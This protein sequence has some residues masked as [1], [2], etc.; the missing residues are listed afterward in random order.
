[1]RAR[2][3]LLSCLCSGCALLS[4]GQPLAPRYFSPDAERAPASATPSSPAQ[5]LRLGQINAAAHLEERIAYRPSP[6]ELGYYDSWRWTEPPQAYL[7]RALARELFE[8]RG[9]V[10]V[11]SGNAPTLSV[12]LTSFEEVR[13][14]QP[15][16][17]V[18]LAVLLRGER[19]ALLERTLRE[20]RPL[21]AGAAEDPQRLTRA[22]SL[23]LDAAVS[24]VADLVSARLAEPPPK[25]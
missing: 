16:A 7:R 13:G 3:L 25:P 23:A 1:M 20:E 24:Q 19:S 12:E 5:E 4:K 6:G 2:V 15:S 18:E 14:A 11:V 17:R 21:P 8:R 22:L 9:V 10:R